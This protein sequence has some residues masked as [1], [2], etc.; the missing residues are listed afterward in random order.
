MWLSLAEPNQLGEVGQPRLLFNAAAEA[1]GLRTPGKK[2]W[3]ADCLRHSFASYRAT[4]ISLIDLARDMGNSENIIVKHYHEV[5]T[6]EAATEFF[7]SMP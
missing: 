7:S 5:A 4:Q 6:P 3:P 2:D 1:A